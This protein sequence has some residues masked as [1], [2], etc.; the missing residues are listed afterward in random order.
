M[1]K[2]FLG[3]FVTALTNQIK[4]TGKPVLSSFVNNVPGAVKTNYNYSSDDG[5]ISEE[6]EIEFVNN[7]RATVLVDRKFCTMEIWTD[8][9]DVDSLL[10]REYYLA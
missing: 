1:K 8:V 7:S 2:R 9:T 4:E 10:V 3:N 6:L 5:R